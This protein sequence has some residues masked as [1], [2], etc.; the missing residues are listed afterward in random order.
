MKYEKFSK[1]KYMKLVAAKPQQLVAAKPHHNN[2]LL[3][4]LG[5]RSDSGSTTGF[6]FMKI[7][8]LSK[9]LFTG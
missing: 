2:R 9:P 1:Y 5:E 6:R 7:V 3:L 4:A 8:F